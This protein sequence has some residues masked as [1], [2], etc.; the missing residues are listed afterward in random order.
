[1]RRFV[2]ILVT[3]SML[4]LAA[5]PASAQERRPPRGSEQSGVPTSWIVVGAGVLLVFA[6]IPLI[7]QADKRARREDGLSLGRKNADCGAAPTVCGVL[8]SADTDA[9]PWWVATGIT[10]GLGVATITTGAILHWQVPS[11]RGEPVIGFEPAPGGGAASL[12]LRF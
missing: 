9:T 4:A 6:A 12:R 7:V 2:A 3:A 10:A 11:T 1:M 5:T 8:A